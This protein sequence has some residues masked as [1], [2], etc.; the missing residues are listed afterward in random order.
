MTLTVSQTYHPLV[1][2]TVQVDARKRN[3]Y[4]VI[5]NP[6]LDIRFIIAPL[7]GSQCPFAIGLKCHL[8]VFGQG[9][10]ICTSVCI[11]DTLQAFG[12]INLVSIHLHDVAEGGFGKSIVG[13][14]RKQLLRPVRQLLGVCK[15]FFIQFH[16]KDMGQVFVQLYLVGVLLPLLFQDCYRTVGT[17]MIHGYQLVQCINDRVYACFQVVIIV[18]ATQDATYAD[19]VFF[20]NMFFYMFIFFTC[21]F[22]YYC[23]NTLFITV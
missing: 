1:S 12:E 2:L 15:S 3:C 20:L 5:D 6:L 10:F 18:L 13:I 22:V 4:L 19:G 8:F 14:P 17:F 16:R 7:F 23:L 11:T 9:C 21:W